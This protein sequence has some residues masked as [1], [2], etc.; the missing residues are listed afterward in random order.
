[1]GTWSLLLFHII[2]RLA[3]QPI[4]VYLNL[5]DLYGSLGSSLDHAERWDNLAKEFEKRFGRP[6]AYITRAPGRIK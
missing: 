2:M 1:M 3:D 4:P 5:A 6:P